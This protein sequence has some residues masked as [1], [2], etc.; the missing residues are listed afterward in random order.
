MR[1]VFAGFVIGLVSFALITLTGCG[2][3]DESSGGSSAA[4]APSASS[5]APVD[6]EKVEGKGELVGTWLAATKGPYVG[7][8]FMDDG[9]AL[10]TQAPRLGVGLGNAIM[11]TYEVLDGGRLALTASSGQTQVFETEIRGDALQLV[12]G[13]GI[14]T[15][16][17]QRFNRIPK[18]Q[19]LKEAHQAQQAAER[20]AADSIYDELQ[21]FIRQ[22]GL[23]IAPADGSTG[24]ASALRPVAVS[25]SDAGSKAW[26]DDKPPHM[27]QI[28]LSPTLAGR[29]KD[30]P[31]INVSYGAQLDPPPAQPNRR[32]PSFPFEPVGEDDD[33][34]WIAKLTLNGQP[35]E[36]ELRRDKALHDAIVGRF[37][38]EKQR[39]AE[40]R[41]PI[42][43][44]LG[45]FVVLEG[46]SGS[47][48]RNEPGG[49]RDRI[50]LVRQ[51][52]AERW[53]GEA[54]VHYPQTG[55]TQPLPGAV[56]TLEM[57]DGEPML[58][59]NVAN[60]RRYQ[61][62]LTDAEAGKLTGG[63]FQGRS[64]NGL[65]TELRVVESM[66]AE[67]FE[68]MKRAKAEKLASVSADT[69]FV[70]A[71]QMQHSQAA[72][73]IAVNL[74]PQADG[75]L[76][77]VVNFIAQDHIAQYAGRVSETMT[78]PQVTLQFKQMDPASPQAG[79]MFVIGLRSQR[80]SFEVADG[81]GPFELIGRAN[82][83]TPIRLVPAEDWTPDARKRLTE[84]LREGARFAVTIPQG[85]AGQSTVVELSI[86]PDSGE[87]SG[88]VVASAQQMGFDQQ[89]APLTGTLT[90]DDHGF[91][92]LDLL[93]GTP[94]DARGRPR[95][96][97]CQIRLVPN[98]PDD[99]LRLIGGTWHAQ[100]PGSK[101][102]FELEQVEE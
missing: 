49:T 16:D 82:N 83:G 89:G 13:P 56:A 55:T 20:E 48:N 79:N 21:S 80:W 47:S 73:P 53:Q 88:E 8:E 77:L 61:L 2:G 33:V 70:G 6:G 30:Q 12:D 60:R 32:G 39:I 92:L 50:V 57:I 31:R 7:L 95:E 5:K 67:S 101:Y 93:L 68:A 3:D 90:T 52:E 38:A 102:M 59:I 18:G 44:A 63:W 54:T 4:P 14:K 29:E 42:L 69:T 40:L 74:R 22:E 76:L 66:D 81:D 85:S 41:K 58:E 28:T 97:P 94:P 96:Y 65:A 45:H 11:V 91:P 71:A 51:G 27:D 19:S 25:V 72:H 84:A 86:D 99:S 36:V 10:L 75:S 17:G 23:V 62:K 9:K 64:S 35:V 34:K 46:M 26:H 98:H 78:G 37:E 100:R 1:R 24:A 15:A 43:D 87:V